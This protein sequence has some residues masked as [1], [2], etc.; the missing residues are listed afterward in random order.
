MKHKDIETN[1]THFREI[2]I[3]IHIKACLLYEGGFLF[4]T[5][6]KLFS[7]Y[8]CIHYLKSMFYQ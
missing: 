4:A 5:F 1:M 2:V 3:K 7:F 6:Q 8:N